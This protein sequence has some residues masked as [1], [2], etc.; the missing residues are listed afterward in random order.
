MIFYF[1]ATG[2]SRH[3]SEMVLRDDEKLV[4][5]SEAVKNN[6]LNFNID[7][8][9]LGFVFPVYYYGIPQIVADFIEKSQ[10]KIHEKTYVYILMTCGGTTANAAKFIIKSLENKGIKTDAVFSVKMVDTYVPLFKL[11]DKEEQK[12]TNFSADIELKRI[13]EK[14][15]QKRSGD[16]NRLKGRFPKA[17]T[18]FSYPF[19]KYRRFTKKFY[20][21]DTCIGC[22][23][24]EKICP[25]QAIEIQDGKPV[26]IKKQCSLCLGCL[27]R[28]PKESIQYGSK[29]KKSGRYFYK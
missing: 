10:I 16:K 28:C 12:R 25:S 1:S 14:I 20:V 2:N 19:Y 11:A 24:C 7:D 22:G 8:N 18:F 21:E 29:T 27:H 17:L 26:W 4:S 15:S 23:L 6:E 13:K 9:T 5:I 3:A